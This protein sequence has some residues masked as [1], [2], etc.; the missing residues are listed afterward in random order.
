MDQ[1]AGANVVELARFG[2]NEE[3]SSPRQ[4]EPA[5]GSNDGGAVSGE[6]APL[7]HADLDVARAGGGSNANCL[8]PRSYQSRDRRRRPEKKA[9]AS[10]IAPEV[11]ARTDSDER[12][13]DELVGAGSRDDSCRTEKDCSGSTTVTTVTT[14]LESNLTVVEDT[15]SEDG[16]DD[17]PS[18]CCLNLNPDPVPLT[19]EE[20]A[21]ALS[22][23]VVGLHDEAV[24]EAEEHEARSRAA[25][26]PLKAGRRNAPMMN[27]L[28]LP[29]R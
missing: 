26:G 10:D 23:L 28:S 9:I 24:L 25:N 6:N 22:R 20:R 7:A 16:D 1:S 29:R 3:R 11:E 17:I 12:E 15:D 2:R 5:R 13:C 8:T 21:A 27:L 19:G 4:S 14:E 18:L